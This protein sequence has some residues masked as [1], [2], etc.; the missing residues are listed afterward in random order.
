MK[1]AEVR[2]VEI[3]GET[4]YSVIDIIASLRNC[5]HKAAQRYFHVLNHRL[6]QNHFEI[7]SLIKIRAEANDGK[8]YLTYFVNANGADF[9]LHQLE[10]SMF[11]RKLR[12]DDEISNYHPILEDYFV[13]KGWHVRHHINLESGGQVDFLV[14][15]E[16]RRLLIECKPRLSRNRFYATVGQLL[17]YHAEHA[18]DSLPVLATNSSQVNPYIV[19]MCQR[20]GIQLL[21]MDN[22]VVASPLFD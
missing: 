13:A 5:D 2:T 10:Q 22:L 3:S 11:K 4:F 21:L 1:C 15:R 7:P 12:N 8:R 14:E 6:S 19:E 18:P 17:C 20:L 9:L 16:D